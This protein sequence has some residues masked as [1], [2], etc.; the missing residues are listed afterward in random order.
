MKM[1]K[2][3]LKAWGVKKN[4]PA[5]DMIPMIRIAEQR[6]SENKETVFMCRGRPVQPGKLRRFAKRHKLMA[7]GAD[8][9]PCDEQGG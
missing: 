7:H 9:A 4:I 5:S 6:R 8:G 2:K 3:H 1:Y